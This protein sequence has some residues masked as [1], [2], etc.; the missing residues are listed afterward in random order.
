MTKRIKNWVG[1]IQALNDAKMTWGITFPL[2]ESGI[3]QVWKGRLQSDFDDADKFGDF[4]DFIRKNIVPEIK[5]TAEKNFSKFFS[6]DTN[7]FISARKIYTKYF[8]YGEKTIIFQMQ[9]S[10]RNLCVVCSL[11]DVISADL[12]AENHEGYTVA[13]AA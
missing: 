10:Y 5:R 11:V 8:Q 3:L 2:S 4:D 6:G 7:N 1:S 13:T 9:G 12:P